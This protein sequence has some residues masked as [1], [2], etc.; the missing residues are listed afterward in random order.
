MP[1]QRRYQYVG[2]LV[3]KPK[4]KAKSILKRT[5][6]ISRPQRIALELATEVEDAS[7]STGVGGRCRD[8]IVYKSTGGVFAVSARARLRLTPFHTYGDTLF[9][10]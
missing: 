1:L 10:Q 9:A 8:P 7:R 4:T 6:G 3:R 2:V 5:W